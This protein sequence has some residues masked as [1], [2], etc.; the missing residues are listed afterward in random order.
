MFSSG[1]EKAQLILVNIEAT[2]ILCKVLDL[3]PAAGI[4]L[5][6]RP[7]TFRAEVLGP[8]SCDWWHGLMKRGMIATLGQRMSVSATGEIDGDF[9]AILVPDILVF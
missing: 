4:V 2:T 9:A 8:S 7:S 3:P 1:H 6:E 5:Q